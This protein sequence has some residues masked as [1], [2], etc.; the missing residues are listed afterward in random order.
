[1]KPYHHPLTETYDACETTAGKP[2]MNTWAF[3]SMVCNGATGR[4]ESDQAKY[5]E[6]VKQMLTVVGTDLDHDALIKIAKFDDGAM[7]RL[8]NIVNEGL[9]LSIDKAVGAK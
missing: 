8:I 2:T 7:L 6:A 1:M 4:I 9:E 3:A 5:I